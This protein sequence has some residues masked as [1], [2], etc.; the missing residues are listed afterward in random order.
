[1]GWRFN[2]GGTKSIEGSKN[3]VFFWHKVRKGHRD[4]VLF[5]WGMICHDYLT[6]G[7]PICSEL[8]EGHPKKW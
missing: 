7:L 8:S 5:M 3:R 4:F 1:M 2:L 6:T